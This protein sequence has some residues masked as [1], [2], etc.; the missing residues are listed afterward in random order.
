VLLKFVAFI[1]FVSL[2]KNKHMRFLLSFVFFFV[3]FAVFSQI[4]SGK[5]GNGTVAKMRHEKTLPNATTMLYLGAGLNHSFRNLQS[6][7]APFGEPLGQRVNEKAI[8]LWTFHFGYKQT[9]SKHFQ[10]DAGLHLDKYGEMFDFQDPLSDSAFTYTNR[11]AFIG[12]PIQFNLT[13]GQR[14]VFS[15]GGGIQPVLATSYKTEQQI[16][17]ANKN[18]TKSS[19]TSLT[20][21]NGFGCNILLS[22]SVQFRFN[23][24]VGIYFQPTYSHGMINTLENQAAYKHYTRGFNYKAG[25]VIYLAD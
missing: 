5:I 23:Q 7:K 20:A 21:L 17:D 25:I 16:T 4:E 22:S 8:D 24:Q 15:V 10:I 6:N 11:Y 9:I 12:L 2:S 13:F 1:P 19:Y 3:G 14:F 18:V